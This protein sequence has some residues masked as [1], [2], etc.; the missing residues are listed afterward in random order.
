[1]LFA[2]LGRSELENTVPEVLSMARG[3]CIFFSLWYCFESN[4]CVELIKVVYLKPG[5]RVHLTF[6][7]HKEIKQ[8]LKSSTL[9]CFTV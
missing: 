2:G 3:M 8:T 4:F 1:M 5:V 9:R 7:A 6:R